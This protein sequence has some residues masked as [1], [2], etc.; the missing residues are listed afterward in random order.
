MDSILNELLEL[1]YQLL[2]FQI[3]VLGTSHGPFISLEARRRSQQ[4]L[5]ITQ[6]KKGES[7]TRKAREGLVLMRADVGEYLN[8]LLT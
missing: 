6:L 7:S 2:N 4:G 5:L 1:V 8:A 3:S